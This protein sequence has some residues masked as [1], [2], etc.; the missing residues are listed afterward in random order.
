[1]QKTENKNKSAASTGNPVKLCFFSSLASFDTGMPICTYKLVTH[2][3]RKP[4]YEVHLIVPEDGEFTARLKKENV[5][6]AVIPFARLRSAS[7]GRDFLRFC[8]TWP[9]AM[10]Q[11]S[12]YIRQN[13]I[14]LVHF[15]DFID[16]PFYPAARMGGAAVVAHLRLCIE[17]GLRRMFFRFWTA[18]FTDK[19]ICISH[20]VKK[21]SGLPD[22]KTEVVLDPGPDYSLFD[23][24]RSYPLHPSL[25]QRKVRVTTIAKFLRVKGHDYF[26]RMAV[27]VEKALPGVVQF[28]I[29]GD[30]QKGHER[31][32]DSVIGL[33]RK[34][35]V[36][37]SV[38]ILGQVTHEEIPAVLS[39][40]RVFVHLP[41]Y[42]EGLGN[43]VC[44]AMAMG[45]PVVAFDSGGVGECFRDHKDGFLVP[46]FDVEAA[47]AGV[48]S[49]VK[50]ESLRRTMGNSGMAFVR[51]KFSL[52]SHGAAMEKAYR[53][54]RGCLI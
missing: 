9:A 50:D 53:N 4:E 20:A 45:V 5:R 44:E 47:A 21:Y 33:A 43:V 2:F 15:S 16:S 34:S 19:V 38:A 24:L 7:H 23:P 11:I 42:Q 37:D 54:I 27:L 46:Q 40:T 30:R 35:G 13:K 49:L 6:V 18:L 36:L 1:M 3:C 48:I 41:R 52:A 10:A 29:V 31:F 14:A 17:K 12:R 28:V 26:V 39:H 25:D 32:Y 22:S 8:M 51:E